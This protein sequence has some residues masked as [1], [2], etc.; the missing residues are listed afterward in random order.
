MTWVFLKDFW[1]K[2]GKI[3]NV[4]LNM[5]FYRDF[6]FFV[7]NLLLIDISIQYSD[8]FHGSLVLLMQYTFFINF[9]IFPLFYVL[10]TSKS[11]ASYKDVFDC[12]QYHFPLH[13]KEFMCDFETGLRKALRD[14]FPNSAIRGCWFHYRRCIRRRVNFLGIS[15][16]WNKAARETDIQK[17]SQAKKVYKVLSCLPLLP[18]ENFS[19]GYNYTHHITNHFN[20]KKKFSKLFEYFARTWIV[21]V[22]SIIKTLFLI[23]LNSF[24]IW[25]CRMKKIRYLSQ[26]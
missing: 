20:L 14:V 21:E 18:K 1:W 23:E 7:W 10:T 11:A 3:A 17:A 4:R 24:S 19:I 2:L 16:L 6:V 25:H 22:W 15:K 9:Q 8:N 5:N 12:I 13:P 26:D